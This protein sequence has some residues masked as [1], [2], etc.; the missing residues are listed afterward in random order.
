M[1]SSRTPK[2]EKVAYA[3]RKDISLG[4]YPTGSFLPPEPELEKKYQVSRATIR[5]AI[6]VLVQE[7]LLRVKQGR[8]TKVLHSGGFL[9]FENV[10]SLSESFTFPK[11][12]TE[13]EQTVLISAIEE[14][15][16]PSA[17]DAEFLQL[18]A[19]ATVYRVQRIMKHNGHAF[20][21]LTNYLPKHLV[22]DLIARKGQF[23]DLYTFLFQT[24]GIRYTKAEE[25]VSA[26]S[27]DLIESEILCVPVNTPLLHLRRTAYCNLG[28]M[29]CSY[30]Q[31]R[32]D[33]Y[34]L[35][36]FMSNE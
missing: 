5:T 32:T 14:V 8:G 21:I 36:I 4:N 30:H 19:N 1:K 16:V 17:Q 23:I 13:D 33:I 9:R 7:G 11:I 24:Y 6:K 29:E 2:Y 35:H 31:I 34:K 27:A 12:A 28:P 10:T 15:P 3:I 25:T 18:P 26:K 20:S 22:P